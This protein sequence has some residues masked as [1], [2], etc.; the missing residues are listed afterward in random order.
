MF[1][2]FDTETTGLP[3]NY[4]A[5]ISD[6]D[7]WPRLVQL[8]WQLHDEKGNLITHRN[9][10]VKPEGFEIPFNSVKI[11][12]ITT[13]RALEEGIPLKEALDE[14]QKDLNRTKYVVGHN[15]EFDINIVGAEF[16][17]LQQETN[18][19]E[20]QSIDTKDEA[21]DFCAIPG[22]KG[23]KFKWPTLTELHTKLF[24]VPFDEAHDAAYDV[25]ATAKCFFAL[26]KEGVI[27][28]PEIKDYAQI[29]YEAP[30]LDEANFAH[31]TKEQKTD[32]NQKDTSANEEELKK[33]D[34]VHL[35]CHSQFSVLQATSRIADMVKIAKN[36]GMPAI[37]LTDHG[38]MMAAFKFVNEALKNDI[39][40]IVGCELNICQ[41]H[42]DK[43]FKDDGYQTVILAKNKNGYHNLA[44]LSSIA[45]T[46]GFY[47]VPRIDKEVLL[48]HK[49]DLIITTGGLWGEIPFKILNEGESRAEEA[50]LWYKEHFGE[51][52]YIEINRHGIEEEEYVN[53]IL[54]KFA[55]KHNIKYFAANNTY[56]DR[57]E[58]AQAHDIL[59]CVKDGERIH[60][61]KKYIGKKGRE[62]RFGFP[63]DEFYIK[64]PEEM[65]KLFNDLPEA[66]HTTIEIAEK[67]EAYQ[68]K[69]DVLLPKFDIP[70][71][72]Q[73]PRDEEDG[74]KRGENNY[75]RY[76][77]YEGAKKRYGEIT[78]EIQERL[79]FELA[80][81]ERTG[82]PGYFL[83]VQDF[84]TKAREMGVSV[85]PGRGSAAGSAVAYCIGIT[86]IDPI[87]YDLLFER[88]LNPDRVS[89]PD[90]DIDFDDEGRQKVIDYV[91]EKYGANQV[92][93]IIT[94]GTMAAKSAI[95]DTA[96]ALDLP[97]DQAD[98]LAKLVPDVKLNKLFGWSEEEIKEKLKPE[99]QQM[100]KQLFEIYEKNNEEGTTVQKAKILEGSLRNTGI[101]A[102]GVIITPDDITKF[103][104]V[105]TAK[106]TDMYCTQFDN[107]VVESAGLLKMDFL[108][109]KTLTL[110]KDA[111]KNVKERHGIELIPDDFPLD[112]KKTYE[113]FQR[114]ETIGVFQYESAGMQKHLRSLKP[115]VFAD[116]IAMNALYRPGPLEY[117]PSFIRRKHGEEEITY[118]LPEMEEY[119]QE[120]YGITVYQEQV[121]LLSQ[122]LAGFTKGEADVLR[123]AMGKKIFSLLE[124]LKPK[125]INQAMEKGH[126]KDKL[127]KIWKDWEAF[128]SYAFNKSH[129][130][131]YAYVAFQT[132]YL[133]AHYPAEYMASVLS[134]NMNDIKSVTFFMEECKRMKIPVLGPDVNESNY[135]F[136][137]NQEGAIRFGLG[138]LKG[139][140]EGAVEAIINARNEGGKFTSIFDFTSRVDLKSC[141]KKTIESL[142]LG[143]GFDSFTNTH[144]A[145]YF[146]TDEKGQT[147]L[148]KAI[149]YGAKVQ[150]NKNSSQIS[151]FGEATGSDEAM[152]TPP[153]PKCE[154]WSTIEKLKKEKEVVGIYLSGHPLDDYK[155]AINHFTS[156]IKVEK[157]QS[158]EDD[159]FE[160]DELVD[161]DMAQEPLAEYSTAAAE[162]EKEW[163]TLKNLS[164]LRY[165][166]EEEFKE[167][168]QLDREYLRLKEEKNAEYKKVKKLLDE[169]IKEFS[170]RPNPVYFAGIVTDINH[171]EIKDGRKFGKIILEDYETHE[172]FM[173]FGDTY[174]KYKGFMEKDW[175]LHI[176]GSFGAYRSKKNNQLT[177]SFRI[178][179]IELLAEVFN[180]KAKGI[181]IE[182]HTDSLVKDNTEKIIEILQKYNGEKSV[183]L[184]LINKQGKGLK[185][186][187]NKQKV[188]INKDIIEELELFS[189]KI[190]II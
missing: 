18:L 103:V 132:A 93:Q 72:F 48:A 110:I 118:D 62:F 13:E 41:N 115:T 102:C 38:N 100:A 59:L 7:N 69:R 107:S 141:N 106:D 22:G 82:Y 108:G 16:Y 168:V 185:M 121:M 165:K 146:A 5:P 136:T 180:K 127:E 131:C 130:T 89:L 98:R 42:L 119:L 160:E 153:I 90:I 188:A 125:F 144:R 40:P 3:K 137:V 49:E 25:E 64:S 138:A 172:E 74:G 86:N 44:K 123:K 23:G 155:P 73:D 35:H 154:E 128:A 95:R 63:N 87:K 65:K 58:D 120:T 156:S 88:F 75:L 97:L 158:V 83:I 47:Y 116:L 1:L 99:Q 187:S 92:A 6:S 133:K 12:G 129:S 169:K 68:L 148:E 81:I 45:Y 159:V 143:G 54:L 189:D 61:P 173:L 149:K 183:I 111:V 46:Q 76:L 85:G 104:P 157:L 117:I 179:N 56:Y 105:A 60:K 124:E 50:L 163:I 2:I 33:A 134:N 170:K 150:E 91:I 19:L 79:D 71:E 122:K 109:L 142:A 145:Q 53:N 11:H 186:K 34:F 171:F 24:G 174:T 164:I 26:I 9:I 52:F 20:L 55:E 182:L 8:A 14:F 4:N 176:T 10:I 139:V 67:I 32:D 94:Y 177:P 96:R 161:N 114:G 126:P 30:V 77:T 101:H 78:P 152:P 178:D 28:R 37:A 29:N 21:T 112:D 36:Y 184:H 84:T 31:Q 66:I 70:E 167:L 190:N 162:E 39:K 135:K 15:I 57:K 43:S 17:R 51:D 175:I 151:L 27:K 80:T 181:E 147:F 166:F 140:G 113:L